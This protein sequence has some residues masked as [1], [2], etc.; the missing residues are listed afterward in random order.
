MRWNRENQC[1]LSVW[2]HPRKRND[3]I[4][5]NIYYCSEGYKTRQRRMCG[6]SSMG[7]QLASRI[8]P[9]KILVLRG[10]TLGVPNITDV[11]VNW[12]DGISDRTSSPNKHRRSTRGQ[13]PRMWVGS[14]RVQNRNYLIAERNWPSWPIRAGGELWIGPLFPLPSYTWRNGGSEGL[15]ISLL[16]SA[17]LTISKSRTQISRSWACVFYLI[18]TSLNF[19]PEALWRW[20][21]VGIGSWISRSVEIIS[22]KMR[23]QR[24]S[25]PIFPGSTGILLLTVGRPLPGT[26]YS[27]VPSLYLVSINI[28]CLE[29]E[30]G[31]SPGPLSLIGSVDSAGCGEL[32]WACSAGWEATVA[33][34]AAQLTTH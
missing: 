5:E 32:Q 23:L 22:L 18:A 3:C 29:Q 34:V 1:Y 12:K 21:G 28:I 19:S 24:R 15:T 13:R 27:W 8:T 31:L 9:W 25:S 11:Q 10:K 6:L 14:P 33:E 26:P 16:K 7:A 30:T 4:K 2:I 17:S 20:V